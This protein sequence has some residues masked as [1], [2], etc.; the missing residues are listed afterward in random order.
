MVRLVAPQVNFVLPDS[1]LSSILFFTA[2]SGIAP[3]I[4]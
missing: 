1:A 2:G 3:V 4:L